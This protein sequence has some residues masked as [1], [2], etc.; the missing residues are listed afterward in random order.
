MKAAYTREIINPILPCKMEGYNEARFC[1]NQTAQQ[2]QVSG[3][4]CGRL[5]VCA[6]ICFWIR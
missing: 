3:E 4:G 6:T 5:A 2:K 1:F